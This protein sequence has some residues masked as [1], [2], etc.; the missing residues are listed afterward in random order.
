M[1]EEEFGSSRID[2]IV[3]RGMGMQIRFVLVC[4]KGNDCS[5]KR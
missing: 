5:F 2:L 4:F 1:G 3:G